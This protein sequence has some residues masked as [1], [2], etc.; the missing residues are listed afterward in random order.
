MNKCIVCRNQYDYEETKRIFGDMHWTHNQCSAICHTKY[1]TLVK[2]FTN[3]IEEVLAFS[4]GE[5][6]PD[7]VWLLAKNK[8]KYILEILG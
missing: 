5:M 7:S 6:T 8:T 4:D 2:F 1:V 3:E